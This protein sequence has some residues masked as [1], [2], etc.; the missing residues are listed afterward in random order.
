MT[1]EEALKELSVPL[2]DEEMMKEYISV[3]KDKMHI[4]DAEFEQIMAAPVHQHTD[5]RVEQQSLVISLSYKV[6]RVYNKVR[7][8]G[9]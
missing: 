2:Y 3:I 1:R 9:R 5:Y 8:M 6:L 4:T 7:T